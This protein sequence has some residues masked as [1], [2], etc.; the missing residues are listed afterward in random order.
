MRS[1]LFR[2][3][4][5]LVF[6]VPLASAASV[7]VTIN[8]TN[9]T[10]P[11][12]NEKGWG[13][14]VTAWIQAVSQYTLQP[15]GGSFS[16]T[17]DT[18]FGANYG[19]KSL[20]LKS[21]ATNVSST[22]ALRLGN[23]DSVGWR[24]AAN[25][26]DLTLSVNASNQLTF[27]GNVLADSSGATFQDSIFT[28]FDNADTTKKLKFEVSGVTTGTTRTLMVPDASTTL[29][30]TD[31]I[32]TLTNKTLTAPVIS[33]I[34]NT[35]T[36]TLPTATDTLV[37]RTTTDTLTN[38]SI[39]GSANTLTA[40]PLSTA[41]TGQLPTAN[42]GTG[43][44]S[45]AVFPTSGTLVTRTAVE[46][47]TNKDLDGGTAS[48]TSR[49]T[50]PSNTKTNLDGLTRKAATVVYATD[51][52]KLYVDD[53]T[54]LSAVGSGS[55]SINY[56]SANSDFEAGTAGYTVSKNTVA[57]AAPDSG[58]VTG[59]TNIT[60][61]QVVANTLAGNAYGLI[62]KG[63]ANRQ[64]E[65]V[66]TPFT[67]D[68][69]Y[70][71]Q[72]LALNMLFSVVS[73]TYVTGDLTAWIY[74]V[75]NNTFTQPSAYQIGATTIPGPMQPIVFQAASNSSSYKLCLHVASTSALAYT[76]GIDNLNIG[77]SIVPVSAAMT[78]WTAYTPTGTWAT[79][80]TYTGF[81][82][83][84]GDM[85]LVRAQVAL[86]GAPTGNFTLNLP[87]GYTIDTTKLGSGL[88]TYGQNLG[89]AS[90][91]S[92]GGA[93][94]AAAVGYASTTSVAVW[95]LASGTTNAFAQL[96][97]TVPNT[98][99]SGDFVWID[100]KVP[101]S[102]WSSNT[103]VSDSAASRVVAMRALT[104]TSGTSYN[105]GPTQV[106]LATVVYDTH[107]KLAS[108]VYTIPVSGYFHINGATSLAGTLTGTQDVTVLARINGGTTYRLGVTTG[109]GANANYTVQGSG[110]T[111]LLNAGDTVDMM[112]QT[113]AA[114]SMPVST[115]AAYTWFE[116]KQVQGPAQ[117]QAATVVA[118]TSS[119]TTTALSAS[120]ADVVFPSVT[121][122]SMS[123]LINASGVFT[124][125]GPGYYEGTSF[126]VAAAVTH[127]AGNTQIA[128]YRI[129]SGSDTECGRWTSQIST[130]TTVTSLSCTI[131]PILL[132]AGD[133]VRIRASSTVST[134]LS[135]G[136]FGIKRVGGIN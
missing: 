106:P 40:I 109:N 14:N 6:L 134:S 95:T 7:T 80:A 117:I 115:T 77:P 96:T 24:N 107:G 130:I 45:T 46:A 112:I 59:S 22:G 30:G 76:L 94:D 67:I 3:L 1:N 12:T 136:F 125:P 60:L 8:G 51:A 123:G 11:Q 121:T 128:Y 62:T 13:N 75:T 39:S 79:N 71:G 25:S 68:N 83:R 31:A 63:A 88:Q 58:F 38:K 87:S 105:N 35:G 50:V 16:L 61:T 37:A 82:K 122:A 114:G 135:S 26:A 113:G 36:V 18:D 111:L 74:D 104:N 124:A 10:I 53:G 92:A 102:G 108:N 55:S 119:G 19:L 100:F 69:G 4:A 56:L 120:T 133:T 54:T 15:S 48:N 42:G 27:A 32:Q 103:I 93:W 131:P 65:Q 99:A 2:I 116:I 5:A 64:G 127:S 73:G 89:S 126:L 57:G 47:L 72:Q 110:V 98:F 41:V 34:T 43:Q 101:I 29:V 132:N 118:A 33:T 28:I 97:A 52:K 78:D 86:S 84:Q 81:W 21:R 49:I 70:K 9:H 66:C 91:L 85:M 23:T 20:Y 44:N 129:N 90:L 17:A